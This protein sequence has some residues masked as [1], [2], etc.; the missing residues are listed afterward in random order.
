[1]PN[2]DCRKEL[3]VKAEKVRAINKKLKMGAK[4]CGSGHDMSYRS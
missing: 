3:M 4:Q 2:H 1:M